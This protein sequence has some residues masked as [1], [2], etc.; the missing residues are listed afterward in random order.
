MD[1]DEAGVQ[2]AAGYGP[3]AEERGWC[4]EGED[5]LA[6]DVCQPTLNPCA[7]PEPTGTGTD[8]SPTCGGTRRRPERQARAES[9]VIVLYSSTRAQG[10]PSVSECCWGA[11]RQR[12]RRAR[13]AMG[14]RWSRRGRVVADAIET[15]DGALGV[16]GVERPV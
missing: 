1:E 10:L 3:K 5:T 14:K 16:A 6:V 4:G 8:D 7:H 2:L 12:R 13:R 9:V 11:K 15:R